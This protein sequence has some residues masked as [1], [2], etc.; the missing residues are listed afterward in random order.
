MYDSLLKSHYEGLKKQYMHKVGDT[1][2]GER[3]EVCPNY[4]S[5]SVLHIIIEPGVELVIF[6]DC[7]S[8]RMQS[9]TF[10]YEQNMIEI[11]CITAGWAKMRFSTE[12]DFVT[13]HKGTL[14]YF[15]WSNPWAY[16]EGESEGFSGIS[17]YFNIDV[18][19]ENLNVQSSFVIEE[20]W[21]QLSTLMFKKDDPLYIVRSSPIHG[22][23]ARQL[24]NG[25]HEEMTDYLSL[26]SKVLEFLSYCM[27]EELGGVNIQG[28][29]FEKLIEIKEKIDCDITEP[30]QVKQLVHIYD[31]PILEL[32]EGFKQLVGCTVYQYIKKKRLKKAAQLLQT[33]DDSITKIAN[34]VGYSNPSKF[35]SAFKAMMF[36]TPL[37]YRKKY[38][39]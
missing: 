2:L 21:S 15:D 19:K 34:E 4:G 29:Q 9:D 13:V 32:Q 22:I 3:Y 38:K 20:K 31:I 8:K 30:L 11:T 17:V 25:L 37:Q 18:L 27:K 7:T 35:T 5:G 16:Y 6:Q 12:E 1:W 39:N 36:E 14:L 23:I 26:K 33:T 24:M 10:S 28:K